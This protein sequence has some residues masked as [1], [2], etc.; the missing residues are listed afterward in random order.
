MSKEL[1]EIENE[2]V[3]NEIIEAKPQQ[4]EKGLNMWNDNKQ[5]TSAYKKAEMLCASDI[6]PQSYQGKPQNCL[7]AIGMANKMGLEPIIVMQNSQIVRGNFT[8][9]GSACKAMIDGCGKY[10]NSRYVEIGTR[11]KDDWGYYLEATDKATGEKVKGVAVTIAMA[12][13]EG[14][15]NKAGSKWQTMPELMLKYRAS[16]FFM[17]T[18]CANVG[19]GFLTAEEMEDIT[20]NK[21]SVNDLMEEK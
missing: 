16:A 2:N 17:R 11:G 9:K 12:K 21:T 18:E 8:W 6:I 20:E 7:V 19:M 4:M 13:A 15:Y 3:E 1:K 10:I 5:M 14:W